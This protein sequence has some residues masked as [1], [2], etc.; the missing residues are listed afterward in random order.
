MY[1]F[2]SILIV[3][4]AL[5]LIGAV[6]IQESKGG[7]LA[8]GFSSSNSIMGV[9]RTTNAIEKIT[10]W[11][12]GIIAVLCI[13]AAHF[14]PK[15]TARSEQAPTSVIGDY[16]DQA[17]IPSPADTKPFGEAPK[18]APAEAPAQPAEP[19]TPTPTPAE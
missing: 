11:L 1:I 13:L 8:A 10:W 6:T 7:G 15:S 14:A 3:I 18:A 19:T 17:T 9:Q 2:L 12:A 16:V 4:T 5:L